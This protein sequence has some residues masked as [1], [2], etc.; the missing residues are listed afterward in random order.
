MEGIP[1]IWL[2]DNKM[3]SYDVYQ[4]DMFDAERQSLNFIPSIF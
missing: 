3:Q 4:S 1:L 2:Y